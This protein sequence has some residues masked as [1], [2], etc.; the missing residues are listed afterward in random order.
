MRNSWRFVCYIYNVFK[1]LNALNVPGIMPSKI[2]IVL[3][4]NNTKTDRAFANIF[5]PGGVIFLRPAAFKKLCTLL[6]TLLRMIVIFFAPRSILKTA[7]AFCV[8][9][10]DSKKKGSPEAPNFN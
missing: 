5:A 3:S 7:L 6:C 4:L 2:A 10:Y 1:M 9:A 8:F